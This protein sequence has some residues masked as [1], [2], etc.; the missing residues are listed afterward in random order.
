MIISD[1]NSMR[2]NPGQYILGMLFHI[3]YATSSKP[4]F[5]LDRSQEA[6]LNFIILIDAYS[7]YLS[8]AFNFFQ[9]DLL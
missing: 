2:L 6:S 3:V 5:A 4:L 7:K 8:A 1:M 9:F